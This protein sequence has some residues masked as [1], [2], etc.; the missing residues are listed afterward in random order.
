MKGNS[1]HHSFRRWRKVTLVLFM[2]FSIFGFWLR[3]CCWSPGGESYLNQGALYRVIFSGRR[4]FG[5]IFSGFWDELRLWE[6]CP[7][8]KWCGTK[9][10]D[11]FQQFV[12][13]YPK[14]PIEVASL[15]CQVCGHAFRLHW[16]GGITERWVRRYRHQKKS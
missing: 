15:W 5:M 6:I 2:A 11:K 12:S 9:V 3:G 16:T 10:W 8:K 14:L 7:N 13:T 1:L 4:G